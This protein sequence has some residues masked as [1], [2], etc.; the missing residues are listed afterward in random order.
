MNPPSP[1]A[2][3]EFDASISEMRNTLTVIMGTAQVLERRIRAG[4]DISTEHLLAML[5]RIR[6][7]THQ[8]NNLATT[9]RQIHLQQKA[10]GPE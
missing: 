7:Q 10:G 2:I 5:S 6:E 8:A 9:L 4:Q 1:Y 3:D